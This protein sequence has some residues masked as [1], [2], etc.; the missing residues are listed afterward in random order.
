MK[1]ASE[2]CVDIDNVIGRTDEVIREIIRRHTGGRVNFQYDD[3]KQFNYHECLDA[4]GNG[5]TREEWA[6]VHQAFSRPEN[7]LSV[8]PVEG[9]ITGTASLFQAGRVHLVT[10]R[11]GAAQ[12]PTLRWLVSHGFSYHQLHFVQHRLKHRD[13][14]HVRVAIEDDYDQAAEFV[15]HGTP[16]VLMRHPW[17]AARP[18]MQGITWVDSW[19]DAVAL[20]LGA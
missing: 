1:A 14:A 11:L 18:A 13:F 4:R 9:A 20:M 3:I 19:R 15:R 7:L 12:A 17:N 2:F 5:I 8:L 10:S 16:C 6:D